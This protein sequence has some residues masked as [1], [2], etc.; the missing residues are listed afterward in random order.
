MDGENVSP[1]V[2]TVK[3]VEL[4]V[5]GTIARL[6]AT[7]VHSVDP[8]PHFTLELF[9]LDQEFEPGFI[10]K[11]QQLLIGHKEVISLHHFLKEMIK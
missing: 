1:T 8:K 2:R 5:G 7:Y 11:G 4:S 9:E 3:I 6:V 10:V